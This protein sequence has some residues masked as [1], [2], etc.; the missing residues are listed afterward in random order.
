MKTH[1]RELAALMA[2]IV[3]VMVG[4][5]LYVLAQAKQ[6]QLLVS[7]VTTTL[8]L[9]MAFIAGAFGL[10]WFAKQGPGKNTGPDTK[11]VQTVAQEPPKDFY[12]G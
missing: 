1:K 5:S 6:Y 10:D 3:H 4:L 12:E 7:L 8:T 2:L 9:D 11:P